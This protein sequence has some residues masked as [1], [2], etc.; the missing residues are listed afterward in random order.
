MTKPRKNNVTR[1]SHKR[2]VQ[3]ARGWFFAEYDILPYRPRGVVLGQSNADSC[4]AACC[5]MLLADSGI[6]QPEAYLRTALRVD[7]GAYLSGLPA[8]LEEFG[9]P[10][11]YEYRNDLT[12][13]DL[14]DA[15]QRGAAVV[16]VSRL[17]RDAGHAL[18][19]DDI[20]DGLVSLRDPLPENL[21]KAYRIWQDDF[22]AVWLRAKT[23]RGMAAIVVG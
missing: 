3:R 11:K 10:V 16:F 1:L 22:W 18:L 12:Y 14:Q 9:L 15:V 20:K 4:V 21:G 19:V 6:E 5:Q 13:A 23:A 7:F 17:E 2:S 8:V